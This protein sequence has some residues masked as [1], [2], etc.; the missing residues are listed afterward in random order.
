MNAYAIVLKRSNPEVSKR[1]RETYPDSY[2]LTDTFFLVQ[3]TGIAQAVATAAG[4]K[5]EDRIKDASGVVFRLNRSYSG[6][7]ERALWDWL[8]QVQERSFAG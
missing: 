1:I 2:S 5:G 3:S 6:Y 4:I 7:T 8:E